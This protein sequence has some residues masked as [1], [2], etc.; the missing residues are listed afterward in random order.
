MASVPTVRRHLQISEG[1]TSR[2]RKLIGTSEDDCQCPL[3]VRLI[4][5]IHLLLPVVPYHAGDIIGGGTVVNLMAADR[6]GE[7]GGPK[8]VVSQ[9]NA[10]CDAPA[11]CRGDRA[12]PPLM[13]KTCPKRS[14]GGVIDSPG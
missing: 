8:Q 11:E 3:R 1:M 6:R 4:V 5:S 13:C 12:T 2:R 14:A 9:A 10:T 7:L